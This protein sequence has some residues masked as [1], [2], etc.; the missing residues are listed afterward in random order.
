MDSQFGIMSIFQT[1]RLRIAWSDFFNLGDWR[2]L[3]DLL[4]LLKRSS[5]ANHSDNFR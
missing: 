4:W 1:E 3:P 2:N 5:L